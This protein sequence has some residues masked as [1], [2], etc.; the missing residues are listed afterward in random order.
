[1][2]VLLSVSPLGAGRSDAARGKASFPCAL[3]LALGSLF[4]LG[5]LGPAA[6]AGQ[7][8][9]MPRPPRPSHAYELTDPFRSGAWLGVSL[10]D[11]TADEAR[12]MKLPGDYGAI[13]AQ[14][15]PDSPAAKAGLRVNDVILEFGGMRV[16][17]AAQLARLVEETPPGR[18]VAL[19]LSRSGKRLNLDASLSARSEHAVVPGFV[20][21]NIHISPRTFNFHFAFFGAGL[22][23]QGET[24]TAQLAEYFG[25]KQGKG[26]L[27]AGVD[28]D[29]PAEKAGLKAGDCIV[30]V[31]STPISSTFDLRSRLSYAKGSQVTLSIVRAKQE[32][33]LT[34]TLDPNWRPRHMM[35]GA[36]PGSPGFQMQ[37][38]ERQFPRMQEMEN[39]IELQ[40]PVMQ[41]R[42][43]QLEQRAQ[44]LEQ[45]IQHLQQQASS[46]EL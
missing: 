35:R 34:A 19:G 46:G 44:Q 36:A 8:P 10:K 45:R 4:A 42:A 17:S 26:V 27:V 32:Q 9:A 6:M 33:N 3:V 15:E 41:Q 25:V 23:I 28:K 40:V 37:E 13:V 14:V 12:S 29:S 16:W 39:R 7:Q 2:N 11:V 30:K 21:P 31:G 22:G 43:Q 18:T 5:A 20:M 24:L 38:L 1:M